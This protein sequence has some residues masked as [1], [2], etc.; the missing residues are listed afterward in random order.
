M[1][2]RYSAI[3]KHLGV[4]FVG[5]DKD[6][7]TPDFD[8]DGVILCTPTENHI[9]DILHFAEKKIP[10]LCEKPISTDLERVLALCNHAREKNIQLRM[11]N[12]YEFLLNE[13]EECAVLY[14]YY[15]H[16]KDGLAWD[17]INII[18]L[19]KP[20]CGAWECDGIQLRETSPIWTTII[21]GQILS[22]A[23][24][25]KAYIAM[26]KHWLS[27]Y[28]VNINYIEKAHRRVAEYIKGKP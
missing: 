18:G 10:I 23:D 15:N 28:T 25:D 12:Q 5:I 26:L 13:K 4:A 14:N 20:N 17:C 7:T 21:N 9:D 1:G 19:A 16:G 11:V 2:R 22:L 6:D 3:L 8:F 27:G 24:M